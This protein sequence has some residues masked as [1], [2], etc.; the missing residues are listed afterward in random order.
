MKIL[1]LELLGCTRLELSGIKKFTIKPETSI[2]ALIGSNSSGKSSLLYYLSPLPADKADFSKDGYKKITI[3]HNNIIYTLTSDFKENK[4]SFYNNTTEEELNTGGT[5]TMQTE[6]VKTYFNYTKQIHL[7]LIG[8]ERFTE[9][10]PSRRK[11]WFT[12]L[13]DT[14]YTYALSVY[15]KVK[16]KHRDVQGALKKI[17]QQQVQ[18]S[19]M[20]NEEDTLL[21]AKNIK[22]KEE[23]IEELIQLA[24]YKEEY[25]KFNF[26]EEIQKQFHL[27]VNKVT[28]V[29]TRFTQLRKLILATGITNSNVNEKQITLDKLKEEIIA[30]KQEYTTKIELYTQEENRVASMQSTSSE[31]IN[32]LKEQ[33]KNYQDQIA[34]IRQRYPDM[35][36]E[37]INDATYL[38][39]QYKDNEVE[40]QKA[41][42]TIAS[43]ESNDS[44]EE[45]LVELTKLRESNLEE[46]NKYKQLVNRIQDRINYYQTR[47]KSTQ[48]T[49]PS[50]STEFYPN[51]DSQLNYLNDKLELA[52]KS[53]GNAEEKLKE[54]DE[55]Y[56]V[57]NRDLQRVSQFL[58]VGR[59]FC[60]I[61]ASS[62]NLVVRYQ[63]H[64]KDP[65]K[66]ITEHSRAIQAI[67]LKSNVENLEKNIVEIE[68]RLQDASSVDEKHYEALKANLEKLNY[69]ILQLKDNYNLKLQEYKQLQS[70]IEIYKQFQLEKENLSNSLEEYDNTQVN[71]IVKKLYDTV[72]ELIAQERNAISILTKKQ[73]EIATREKTIENI[74][75]QIKEYEAEEEAYKAILLLLNPQD[76]LIAEGLLGYIKIFLSRLNGFIKNIWTYPLIVHPSKVEDDVD[77]SYRF[78]VTVGLSDT[79]KNDIVLGSDGVREV[80]DLAFKMVAMKAL[81]LK[82]Y[83]VYLD[84]FGRTFDAAHRENALK[85]VEKLSEEFIED[86]IFMVSHSFMEYSVLND[87]SFCVLS[88]DNIV[89]PPG[90]IN[91]GVIIER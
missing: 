64:L 80:I 88:Q 65:Y 16:E 5:L 71:L 50:C 62:V 75:K 38:L 82:G 32:L 3:E 87:V 77:L 56:S 36:L 81:G 78:P 63:I 41:L 25:K 69:S 31:E 23:N 22:D 8:K 28:E 59:L 84:E 24:S 12:L 15:N 13:C 29:N 43:I 67:T 61:L 48:V 57:C 72:M 33:L 4:H 17:K 58:S 66:L 85:L 46:V 83:P 37:N 45:Y 76:G 26:D 44:T 9:M 54:T 42:D 18:L 6:L 49:C 79:P 21:I 20:E 35:D 68:K 86:Q 27:S 90:E 91:R 73:I 30:L 11:D 40:I 53:L 47:D 19:S 51:Y 55:K 34:E 7:L 14:D 10:S 52:L 70:R 2:T 60:D 39:K 74:E 1:E 89:L